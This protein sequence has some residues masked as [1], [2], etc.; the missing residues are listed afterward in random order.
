MTGRI[1]SCGAKAECSHQRDQL[2]QRS[3]GLLRLG[4]SEDQEKINQKV[5]RT[6]GWRSGRNRSRGTLWP[7]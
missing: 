2:V 6:Q 5:E 4:L 3:P 7:Q 1:L